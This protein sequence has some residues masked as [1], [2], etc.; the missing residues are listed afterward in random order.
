MNKP[1]FG[2][3]IANVRVDEKTTAERVMTFREHEL[4][5]DRLRYEEREKV[6]SLEEALVKV[7]EYAERI[8][9]DIEMLDPAW[10]YEGRAL[11]P[12]RGYFYV[13]FCY[14]RVKR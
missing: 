9:N 12:V 6:Q 1:K 4:A 11:L 8:A 3:V 7:S 13:I 10:R 14:T 2:K 5:D